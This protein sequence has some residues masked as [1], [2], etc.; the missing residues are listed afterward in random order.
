MDAQV[1]EDRHPLL[2]PERYE[3]VTEEQKAA[4]LA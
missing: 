4:R 3:R 2:V 1:L